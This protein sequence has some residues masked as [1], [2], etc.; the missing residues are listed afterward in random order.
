VSRIGPAREGCQDRLS[1]VAGHA[2][3]ADGFQLINFVLGAVDRDRTGEVIQATV[4]P[5]RDLDWER[6]EAA[7]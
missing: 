1:A 7:T 4:R 6:A 3:E 2:L 5:R